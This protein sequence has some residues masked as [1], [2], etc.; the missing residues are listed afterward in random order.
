MWQ[1]VNVS[2]SGHDDKSNFINDIRGASITF[3]YTCPQPF[4][5]LRLSFGRSE[6]ALSNQIKSIRRLSWRG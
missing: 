5:K 2:S 4:G 1:T 6:Q 3:L